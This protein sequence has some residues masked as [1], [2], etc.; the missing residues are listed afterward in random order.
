[1]KS[2]LIPILIG[3]TL[4]GN[5]P[6]LSSSSGFAQMYEPGIILSI[7]TPFLQEHQDK[8]L[9]MILDSI[10][11][12]FDPENSSW[13]SVNFEFGEVRFTNLLFLDYEDLINA[14]KEIAIKGNCGTVKPDNPDDILD[15]DIMLQM[16]CISGKISNISKLNFSFD[17]FMRKNY[18]PFSGTASV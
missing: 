5:N 14:S 11:S 10:N 13:V 15:P 4:A 1:M 17:F 12:A 7:G 2:I 9:R 16:S 3:Q 18:E 8:I 6:K